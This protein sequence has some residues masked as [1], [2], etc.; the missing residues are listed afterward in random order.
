MPLKYTQVSQ[1]ILWPVFLMYVRTIQ[2]LNYYGQ[3]SKKQ[4]AAYD[5]EIPVTLKQG[6]GHQTWY[7]L[8]DPK[9][10]YNNAKF[11]KPRFNTVSE[12]A[13]YKVFV[14]SGNTLVISL[15]YIGK[16]NIVVY[17]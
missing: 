3:E 11:G 15:H 14:K 1:H 13:S 17:P 4:F 6:Q 8:V 16:S 5:S 9:Q 10:G 2:R 7:K 12:K